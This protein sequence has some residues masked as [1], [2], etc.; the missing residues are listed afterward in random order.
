MNDI[1]KEFDKK[2]WEEKIGW[3]PQGTWDWIEQKLKEAESK[4]VMS[5]M[6]KVKNSLTPYQM[7]Y[8]DSPNRAILHADLMMQVDNIISQL[9]KK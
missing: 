4:G 3:K 2:E 8:E 7:P 6:C 5:G 9:E 1:K